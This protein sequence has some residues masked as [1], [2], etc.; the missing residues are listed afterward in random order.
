MVSK[1]LLLSTLTSA[2]FEFSTAVSWIVI[3]F[4]LAGAIAVGRVKRKDALIA[5]LEK[6]AEQRAREV[7][8]LER[9]LEGAQQ[10]ANEEHDKR[11][12]CERKV[13]R[14]EGE[15]EEVRRYTARGALGELKDIIEHVAQQANERNASMIE[16][17]ERIER[18]VVSAIENQGELVLKNTELI[19]RL[20]QHLGERTG[21]LSAPAG[22]RHEDIR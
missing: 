2:A 1:L 15:L 14:S 4:G 19:A 9:T 3:A 16:R 11:R 7:A 8:D 17:Q 12:E 18:A 5:D 21:G 10:R 13:A 6:T 22:D 20:L